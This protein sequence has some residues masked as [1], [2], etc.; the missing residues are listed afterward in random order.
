MA[1]RISNGRLRIFW[2]FMTGRHNLL[3]QTAHSLF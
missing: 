3:T 2:N 1:T